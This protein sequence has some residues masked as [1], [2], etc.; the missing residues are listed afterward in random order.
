MAR[1]SSPNASLRHSARADLAYIGGSLLAFMVLFA[2]AR[3]MLLWRNLPL[4]ADVP[5]G[6]LARA[7]LVGM[8]FDLAMSSYV[9][10]PLVLGMFLPGGLS[11]RR[12]WNLWLAIA[13]AIFSFLAVLELD[14]YKEF[15]ARLNSLV[16]QYIKEDP[17]TVASMLWY[18][19]PVLRYL[20]LTTLLAMLAIAALRWV[21][22]HTRWSVKQPNY[23]RR[24]LVTLM[25]ALLI[26]SCARGTFRSGSPL[27][28]GD[29][30]F[31][32]YLF[33]NHLAL[34][35]S[36]TL[37]KAALASV[38]DQRENPWLKHL[39]T[40]DALQV[41]HHDLV[42][43]QE[44]LLASDTFPMLRRF[45]PP[46]GTAT[47]PFRNV[48][49]I[50]SE[51]FSAQRVGVLG[52]PLQV[53]PRF[54]ALAKD[55]LLFTRFFSVGTHTHQGMFGTFSCFP[56]LPHYEYLMKQPEGA[57]RFSGLP[58]VMAERNYDSVYVYNGDFAWDNQGGFFRAQGLNKLVGRFD[59]VN[60]RF[61]DITWGVSDED[62]F[63]R[64]FEEVVRLQ[65]AGKPYYAM[66]QTLSNHTPYALPD[67]LPVEKVMVDG[68]EE[69]HLTAMR[70]ADYALGEFFKKVQAKGNFFDDTLFVFVGDHG[71]GGSRQI[72][73]I[74]LTRFHV[75]LLF[76]GKD[77]QQRFGGTRTTVGSQVDIVPTIM[78]LL[79]GSYVHN[80]W[81]RDLL[82]LPAGDPGRAIIKPSGTDQTVAIIEGDMILSQVPG[83]APK[84]ERIDL[85]PRRPRVEPLDD[86]DAAKRLMHSMQAFFHAGITALQDNKVGHSD[87]LHDTVVQ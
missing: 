62:M 72:T 75:P 4:A 5:A 77:I 59:F 76:I 64:G 85:D 3:G 31:G 15:H 39:S 24:V 28:W 33:A 65:Q 60:P 71:F 43:P 10:V 38:A 9:L 8:R 66:L 25:A 1:F 53:T 23:G 21:D 78:G 41:L 36:F 42:A 74:D 20:L 27:R 49:L 79:G 50:L 56:N 37:S 68:V 80:C 16:F 67:P 87:Q 46:P 12:F 57:H 22:R 35:G 45:D 70:Y 18:G 6:E 86:A 47:S 48:V 19:F 40:A 34:N 26:T 13:A 83:A 32:Q 82:A 52:S 55:G 54:D 61:S 17:G 14:F 84:L 51:S 81:G 11:Q 69:P 63:D 30:F 2:V 73:D 58:R 29:A 7:F 44:T